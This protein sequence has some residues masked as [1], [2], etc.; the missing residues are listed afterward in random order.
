MLIA[1][2]ETLVIPDDPAACQA[3]L[4]RFAQTISFTVS[5]HC[6]GPDV[7]W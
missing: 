4:V 1:M 5:R 7:G 6:E 3:M 2:N